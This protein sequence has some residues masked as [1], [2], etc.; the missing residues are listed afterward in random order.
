MGEI[1][2]SSVP[3]AISMVSLGGEV[4]AEA[5]KA[6]EEEGGLVGEFRAEF[7]AEAET[8]TEPE[9]CE[10]AGELAGGVGITCGEGLGGD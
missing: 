5:G 2:F 1:V 10:R 9:K 6:E 3:L 7:E 8:E 4:I